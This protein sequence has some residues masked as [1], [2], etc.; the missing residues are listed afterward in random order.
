MPTRDKNMLTVGIPE[1][2]EVHT[3][4][5]PIF[6]PNFFYSLLLYWFFLLLYIGNIATT[7]KFAQI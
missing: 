3:T 6:G 5:S 2:W 1:R 7:K 4:K